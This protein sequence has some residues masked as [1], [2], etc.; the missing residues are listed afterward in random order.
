MDAICLPFEKNQSLQSCPALKANSCL[1]KLWQL[2]HLSCKSLFCP[3]VSFTRFKLPVTLSPPPPQ[4]ADGC[5]DQ[6]EAQNNALWKGC[7][8]AKLSLSAAPCPAL[9]A[10]RS[11]PQ[12]HAQSTALL[13]DTVKSKVV[14]PQAPVRPQQSHSSPKA[15]SPSSNETGLFK[16]AAF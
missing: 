2:L 7:C 4:Q 14:H 1:L 13:S 10:S 16:R 12:P 8:S 5:A 11:P 3:F 6:Q 9:P 15:L